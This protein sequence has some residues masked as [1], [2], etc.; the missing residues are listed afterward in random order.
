MTQGTTSSRI[1]RRGLFLVG[2]GAV[3][4]RPAF[5]QGAFPSRPITLIV[6]FSAGG[7]TDLG[8]RLLAADVEKELGTTIV[9]ENREGAGSQ[10]GTTALARARPDGYTIGAINQPAVD[11]IILSPQRQAAFTIDSF[12]WLINHVI[13]PLIIAVR[14]DA[15]QNNLSDLVAMARSR[16][17]ELRVGTSGLLTPEHLAQLQFEQA[18]NSRLRIAHFNGAADSMTQFRGGRTDIAFT[19][20]SFMEDVKPLAILTEARWPAL[21]NLATAAEQGFPGLVMTSSRGF[22][23][24]KGVPA[25]VLDR[26]RTA[27]EK[28]A[29]SPEHQ[30]KAAE[31]RLSV[32]VIA[33]P[34]YEE[35]VKRNHAEAR[36]LVELSRNRPQ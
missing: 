20:P 6:P 28:V 7:G 12:D 26:L 5:A 27:F 18:A 34:A 33:G 21:P 23:V 4:A 25:P 17:G 22:A 29:R 3:L 10:V 11:T 30:A 14:T 24:P 16:P 1:G 8:A 13:E 36:K 32:F 31:R 9:V 15:P 19:T 2:A 35:F